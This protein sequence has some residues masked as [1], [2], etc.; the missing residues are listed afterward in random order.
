[1]TFKEEKLAEFDKKFQ[2]I[3][4][5]K[6][7]EPYERLDGPQ[8]EHLKAFFSQVLDEHK[9]KML[10]AIRIQYRADNP[11]NLKVE[12]HNAALRWLER[13]VLNSL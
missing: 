6:L 1:M 10:K 2:Y 4:E 8:Y 5:P 3:G 13:D 11:V 12:S 7:H 9:A